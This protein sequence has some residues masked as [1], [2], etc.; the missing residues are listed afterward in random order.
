MLPHD[1]FVLGLRL[2]GVVVVLYGLAYL[3]DSLLWRLGYYF[4]PEIH[5]GYYLIFGLAYLFVGLYLL[6]GSRQLVR[7]V[8]PEVD[9]EYEEQDRE[10]EDLVQNRG[11]SR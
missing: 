4:G 8:Y 9:E 7:L 11:E 1:W 5:I 2:I 6:L 10:G 3:L